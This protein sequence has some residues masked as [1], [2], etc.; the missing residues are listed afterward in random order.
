MLNRRLFVRGVGLLL[1]ALASLGMMTGC[2]GGGDGGG[3]SSS[4]VG[5]WAV[6]EGTTPSGAPIQWWQFNEDGTFA[7]YNNPEFTSKHLGGTYSQDGN[8]VTGPFTNPGVGD[9]EIEAVVSDDGKSLQIDFIEH[10]HTPY[11][12]VPLNGVKI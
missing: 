6:Y 3:S 5:K 7:Y 8:K 11:K 9:G 12:H 10:W 2:E 4:V 1:T